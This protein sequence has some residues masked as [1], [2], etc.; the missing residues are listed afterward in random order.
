MTWWFV[1]VIP[2]L[3]KMRHVGHELEA[4]LTS[5]SKI[6]KYKIYVLTVL[7]LKTYIII[8]I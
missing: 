4:R 2:V 7:V 5:T 8:L 3:R 1:P 6:N